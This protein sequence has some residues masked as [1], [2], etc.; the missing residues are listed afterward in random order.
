M[1]LGDGDEQLGLQP[2]G[3][4]LPRPDGHGRAD[5]PAWVYNAVV[6][7]FD[8]P[9]YRTDRSGRKSP[10]PVSCSLDTVNE[11]IRK[12]AAKHTIDRI[13]TFTAGCYAA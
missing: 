5:R 9:S 1:P 7:E 2:A 12:E 4:G 6:L 10:P 13:T 8:V 11:A 3:A